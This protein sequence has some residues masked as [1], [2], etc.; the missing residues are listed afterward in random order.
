MWG[1]H[2]PTNSFHGRAT[3]EE[4]RL[5]A[6]LWDSEHVRRRHLGTL[7]CVLFQMVQLRVLTLPTKLKAPN[8]PLLGALALG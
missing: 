6:S 3:G 4:G 2:S 7:P 8:R 5:K 1:F